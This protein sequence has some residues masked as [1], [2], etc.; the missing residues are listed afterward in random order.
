MIE[1]LLLVST[2]SFLILGSATVVIATLVLR[3]ARRYVEL[4]EL[5]IERLSQGQAHLLALL[6]ESPQ[7]PEASEQRRNVAKER[8][9]S[10]RREADR[11]IE[12]LERELRQLR[13]TRRETPSPVLAELSQEYTVARR[14]AGEENPSARKTETT[15]RPAELPE[16]TAQKPPTV[17][18]GGGRSGRG[19]LVPHPDDGGE[20]AAAVA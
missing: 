11:R 17:K 9:Q 16:T 6:D 5:R 15:S 7:G 10:A 19:L 8:E 12:Q 18:L 4:A 2:G 1:V 14:P 3:K 20:V 13:G